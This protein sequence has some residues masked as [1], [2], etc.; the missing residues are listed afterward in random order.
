VQG[1]RPLREVVADRRDYRWRQVLPAT[2]EFGGPPAPNNCEWAI[3]VGSR[4]RYLR[5]QRGETLNQFCRRIRKPFT[6]GKCYSAGYISRLERGWAAPPFFVYVAIAEALEVKPGL[7]F[8]SDGID[9]GLS[10]P[11]MTLI[12]FIRGLKIQPHE[13]M[14]RLARPEHPAEGEEFAGRE[15]LA[16]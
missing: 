14:V 9:Q 10:Q 15:R 2:W 4:I 11:E 1:P 13:A 16:L 3:V 8:G 12:R 6:N 7:L 5:Q